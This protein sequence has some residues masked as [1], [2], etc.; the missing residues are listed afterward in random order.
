MKKFPKVLYV[1]TEKDSDTSYF[2][3]DGDASC[4]VEMGEKISIAT[5]TL[6]EVRQAEGVASFGEKSRS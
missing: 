4:L 5:Y 2:V 1:K 6:T 3:A